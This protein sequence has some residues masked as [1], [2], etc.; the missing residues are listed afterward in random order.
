[1]RYSLFEELTLWALGS[2]TYLATT[3]RIIRNKGNK[4]NWKVKGEE[5]EIRN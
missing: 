2:N 3:M 1:M 4:K 5:G